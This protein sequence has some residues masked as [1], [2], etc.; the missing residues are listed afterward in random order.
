[1]RRFIA[2]LPLILAGCGEPAVLANRT[3]Q[4]NAVEA[5][6]LVSEAR[7]VRIGELGASFD[8]CAAA[9][10]PRN[11]PA[12]EGLPVRAAPFETASASGSVPVGGRFFICTRSLD[13][14]WL[15]IVW[16]EEG[17][18]AER[19][20]VSAP[21]PRRRD[22]EG[23]CRAGWVQSAF[24]RFVSGVEQPAPANQAG[25]PSEAGNGSASGAG[26]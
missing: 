12:G 6:P 8:A 25:A 7:P 9:G 1:M 17:G 4:G 23:P 10:I 19:C 16:A 15:G 3:D 20:G 18:L 5:E 22:Y 26:A 24:V 21:V 13:Q 11:L 2:A 14:K